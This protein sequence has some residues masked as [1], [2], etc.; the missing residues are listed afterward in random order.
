MLEFF[1]L[2]GFSA[3]ASVQQLCPLSET[4][5]GC[6]LS[7]ENIEFNLEES[8]AD[9]KADF[10][11]MITAR[12]DFDLSNAIAKYRPKLEESLY[13]RFLYFISPDGGRIVIE[14]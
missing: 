5:R 7:H 9:R 4:D 1:K 11:L 2:L 12:I 6:I 8:S 14:V 13:G 3:D 10:N